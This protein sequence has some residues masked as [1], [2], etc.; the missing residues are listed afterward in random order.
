MS[1]TWAK[2]L[3]PLAKYGGILAVIVEWVAVVF[4][5]TRG[6]LQ[7]E[8]EQPIS[9]FS[10]LPETK[11]VFSLCFGLAAT[12][13]WVFVVGHLR[14][15]YTTPTKLFSFAALG[16]LGIALVPYDPKDQVS[17]LLHVGI[18]YTMTLGF[19]FGIYFIGSRNTDKLL[20][21]NTM[22]LVVSGAI[23]AGLMGVLPRSMA[24]VA[25]QILLGLLIQLWIIWI[26]FYNSKES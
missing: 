15:R 17:N 3:A 10:T 23:L 4:F 7:L 13:F 19:L 24:W 21:K 22:L 12:S 9:Y 1:F 25:M 16:L 26:T 18:A 6:S 14:T 8:P 5:H 20:R 2:K 11:L